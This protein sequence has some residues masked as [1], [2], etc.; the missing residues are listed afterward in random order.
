MPPALGRRIN[1]VCNRFEAAWRSDAA[2]RLEEFL[3]GWEGAERTALLRELVPL[4][5][6]Y[7]RDR[8]K[9]PTPDD[10]R[11]RFPDLDPS[12]LGDPL[13]AGPGL[14]TPTVSPDEALTQDSPSV[15]VRSFGDYEGLEEVARG[16]MGVVYRAR[17]RRANRVV[18]LKM[19][20]AGEFASPG[21]V[22]RFCAEARNVARLDHPHIVPLYEVGEHGGLPFFSMK[23]VGGG[24]LAQ[25]PPSTPRAAAELMAKVARAV[26]HAPPARHPAPGHQAGQHPAGR[27]GRALRH[28]LRPGQTRGGGHGAHALG[29]RRRHAELHGAGAGGGHSKRLT[30]AADVYGLGAVLYELLAGRPPFKGE[31]PLETLQQV[32]THEPVPPSR[33]RPGVPRPGS[34]LPEV[35]AQGAGE[36]LRVG[37]SAGG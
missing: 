37:A 36:S 1:E 31:M 27:G 11:A 9:Q 17:Q 26:H 10:Y 19:I 22:E 30:T 14:V 29:G 3:A 13:T 23:Y 12:C 15:G 2:P 32:L 28:R 7:R 20:L 5:A 6:D 33:L 16:G 4:D 34:D 35:P 18:A 21:D 8:G 25:R 24:S